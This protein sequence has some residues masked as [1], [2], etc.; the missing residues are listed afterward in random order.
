MSFAGINLSVAS[1]L[2][3]TAVGTMCCKTAWETQEM[4]KTV[5]V[6]MMW[7]EHGILSGFSLFIRGGM[8][9]E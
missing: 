7:G 9:V 4:L 3:L 1:L 6:T 2:V 5:S 8:S